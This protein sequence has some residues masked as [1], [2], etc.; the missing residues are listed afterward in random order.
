MLVILI[1][2]T[3]AV[4]ADDDETDCNKGMCDSCNTAPGA[5]RMEGPGGAGLCEFIYEGEC[6]DKTIGPDNSNITCPYNHV[7]HICVCTECTNNE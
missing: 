1:A 7:Y 5:C 6:Q 2:A 3:V 4:Q